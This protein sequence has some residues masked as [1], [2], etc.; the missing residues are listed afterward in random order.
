MKKSSRVYG[1]L[2]GMVLFI[3]AVVFVIWLNRH[4][5]PWFNPAGVV[6]AS[7]RTVFFIVLGLSAVV[8]IPVFTMLILFAVRYREGNEKAN[9]NPEWSK[10][11]K[12]EAIWWGIPILII[13]IVGTISWVSTHALDPYKNIASNTKPLRV[14]VVTLEW[15]WLFIYPDQGVATINKL[16]I[17][18]NTPVQLSLSAD[19]PMSS[20][21][22]P[23]LGSQ[24]YTMNG[25]NTQLHL[26]ATKTGTFT[27]YNTNIN[28][29]GYAKMDFT[30]PVVSK[31]DFKKWTRQ[32]RQSPDM[33]DETEYQKIMKPS[34]MKASKTYM[35][36]DK[37]LYDTIM[38]KY[39]SPTTNGSKTNK[40]DDM[41][42]MD[43]S[44]M[45]G[46]N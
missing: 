15:K 13:L 42:G 36:M 23:S 40:S 9:Y 28:G 16:E 33:L 37:D 11:T 29:D 39:M 22:V 4:A 1:P 46:M 38:M 2:L 41:K 7:E 3:A 30:V 44:M 6:A 26:M 14:Q 34:V 8:V 5:F 43:M 32:S 19:A 12:L 27:G 10:N 24:I 21:W 25:M 20:F 35:L 17:P 31:T 45:K 18:V